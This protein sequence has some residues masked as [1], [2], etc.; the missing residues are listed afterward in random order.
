[1]APDHG[2]DSAL[3]GWPFPSREV[4]RQLEGGPVWPALGDDDEVGAL[5]APLLAREPA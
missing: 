5:A 1:M 3:D 2:D 4:L